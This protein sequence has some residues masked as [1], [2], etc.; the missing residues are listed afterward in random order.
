MNPAEPNAAAT[1]PTNPADQAPKRDRKKASD[2]NVEEAVA[3]VHAAKADG[4]LAK[5]S[6]L[7]LKAY[8]KSVGKPVGGKKADLIERVGATAQA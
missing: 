4:T 3:K 8:L 6:L 5:L 1:D 7:E 2:I